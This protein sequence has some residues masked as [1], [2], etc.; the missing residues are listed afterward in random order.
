M[1]IEPLTRETILEILNRHADEIR[2]RFAVRQLGLFG[3]HL[4]QQARSDSDVDILVDFETPTFD[5]YMDLKFYLETLLGREVDL[6][7]TESV[8][9]RLKPLILAEVQH[10]PRLR[11]LS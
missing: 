4:R 6:V 3:S 1:S 5:N 9:P 10:V 8:K 2:H 11:A 7:M